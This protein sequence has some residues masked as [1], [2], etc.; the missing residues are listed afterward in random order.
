MQCHLNGVTINDM[1]KFL[2]K[3]PTV[4]DHAVI[5]PSNVDDSLLQISL[6]L[7]GITSH[8]PVQAATLSEFKSDVI[9]KFHF[10]AEALIWDPSLSSFSLQE[11]SML[12]FRG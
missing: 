6:M 3:N 2:L 11:D 12:D 5:V 1:P 9:L 4:D 7:Q 10:T 8:F